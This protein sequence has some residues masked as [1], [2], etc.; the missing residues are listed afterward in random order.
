MS[1]ILKDR[2]DFCGKFRINGKCPD[3]CAEKLE[4]AEYQEQT[5]LLR[6]IRD[7]MKVKTKPW[8]KIW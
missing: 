7:L 4:H 8:W 6:E 3:R 5:K 1:A 2:C